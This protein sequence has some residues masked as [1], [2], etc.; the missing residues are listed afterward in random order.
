MEGHGSM[1]KCYRW[2]LTGVFFMIWAYGAIYCLKPLETLDELW[3][4]HIAQEMAK[5]RLPYQ[6]FS[7]IVTPL[8]FLV[9]GIFLRVFWYEL[10]TI[11]SLGAL[12]FAG[13]CFSFFLILRQEIEKKMLPV[14]FTGMFCIAYGNDYTYDYNW[15]TLF[16]VM[17]IIYLQ[18]RRW[19]YPKL[20]GQNSLQLCH[21]K[22]LRLRRESPQLRHWKYLKFHS[23]KSLQL[24]CQEKGH[25]RYTYSFVIGILCG[26]AFMTKQSTGLCVAAVTLVMAFIDGKKQKN[27][28]FL[29]TLAG[30]IFLSG[31][32]FWWLAAIGVEK[33]FWEYCFGG[34]GSFSG[35]NR[36]GLW[37]FV[38]KGGIFAVSELGMIGMITAAALYR[39]YRKPL[40]RRSWLLLLSYSIS[41][42]AVVYPIM[43]YTHFQVAL[44]PF[45][46]TGAKLLAGICKDV[47]RR[48]GVVAALVL[49]VLAIAVPFLCFR[50]E[51][52]QWS[53]LEH[54]RGIRVNAEVE[55]RVRTVAD[56][57]GEEESY[58]IDAS[59]ALY[60][61]PMGVY[62]KNYDMFNNGNFG[63]ADPLDLVR[64]LGE[65]EGLIL[66]LKEEYALNWQTPAEAIQY[67]RDHYIRVDEVSCFD[68]YRVE[69]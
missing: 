3:M 43:D 27:L 62:H 44:V 48:E 15:L 61:I 38:Q 7:V 33:E 28:D 31:I 49:A 37:E 52:L 9:S 18:L 39:A 58:I 63:M 67:I 10:L 8:S 11:R 23:Q 19:K 51:N 6:D 36:I 5:G 60:H 41:A 64:Q 24:C 2:K 12:V 14:I 55:E 32:C 17:L 1:L 54:F 4:Y 47:S 68:V 40:E 21:W 56:Y 25:K 57:I 66:V 34:L 35:R 46:V 26:M 42:G 30:S 69:E 20:Y 29:F 45:F 53:K 59:A 65:R 50:K 13:I 22:Y 16:E